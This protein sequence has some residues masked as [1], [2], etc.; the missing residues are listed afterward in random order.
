MD[1][2]RLARFREVIYS[3]YGRHWQ[4]AGEH[5][6]PAAA[7]RWGR[8]YGWYLRGWLPARRD[9][10]IADLACGQGRLLY[11]LKSLGYTSLYGVDIA[12]DQ[13]ALAR[14]VA[15]VDQE[16]LLSWLAER[17]ERFDLLIGLD[18]IEHFA[19]DEA[20]R[21]LE[22]AYAALKPGGRLVLQT[23]NADSPFG[24]QVR[25]GDITH[26][27]AYNVNQLARL[28]RRAGF[29]AI[30]AREQG[31]VPWGYSLASTARFLVWRLIRAG[32]QLWNLAETG[33]TLPVLTRVFLIKADKGAA[34]D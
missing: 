31:P 16:D 32:L 7:A 6:D 28:L 5:F 29:V 2:E 20:L 1:A 13:V 9:A 34:G 33:A 27:W 11:W 21:F 4:D 19:R 8:A 23:P 3:S 10:A 22:L 24:L 17:P 30:E 26:E 18:I 12:P 15:N 25:Y 14:Q